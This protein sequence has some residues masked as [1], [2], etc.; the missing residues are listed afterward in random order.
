MKN[1]FLCTILTGLF[2]TLA[3]CVLQAQ[4]TSVQLP[5]EVDS[6]SSFRVL[7]HTGVTR[8]RVNS[9]GGFYLGGEYFTG[10]IPKEGMGTRLMWYSRKAAFRAGDIDGTQWDDANIGYASTAM[11]HNTTASG[12][13]STAMGNGTTAN[14]YYSTA[15]G[16][17]TAASAMGST[18]MGSGTTA[19]GNYSTAMGKGTTASSYASTA[20]G[21]NTTASGS[22]STA[23]GSHVKAKHYG[24]FIIGDVSKSTYDSSSTNNQM[25]TRFAGG[26]RMY[27][28]S[29]LTT[30]VYMNGGVSGW[31]NFCDRNRKENFNSIDGEQLLVKIRALPITEWNYKGTDASVK[32]IGPV[33]QDFYSAFLL[34]GTDSLGINSLCIDGVNMAAIQAL[35]KRTAELHSALNELV[36]EKEKVAQLQTSFNELKNEIAK[37]KSDIRS[38]TDAKTELENENITLNK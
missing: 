10:V 36:V 26:Y 4:T 9:D 19:S 14:D 8:M 1:F 17:G 11:G 18:A 23:M 6:S 29:A 33:A 16:D 25:T 12:S 3:T 22:N 15:M 20:T 31:T 13:N 38:F 21:E 27:S 28:N 7:N 35:E 32:Y 24:V 2:L 37:M 34:G 5:T 30:G